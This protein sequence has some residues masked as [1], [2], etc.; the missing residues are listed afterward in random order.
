MNDDHL[1]VPRHELKALGEL[2]KE[3]PGLVSDL[4]VSVRRQDRIGIPGGARKPKRPSEQPLPYRIDASEAGD[5]LHNELGTWVRIVCEYRGIEDR[6]KDTTPALARW[7]DTNL[8]ALGMTEGAQA[9]FEAIGNSVDRVRWIVCPPPEVR[10]IDEHRLA[11]ARRLRLNARGI[12]TLATELG[13]EYRHLSK[14]RVLYLHERRY[15]APVPGPWRKDIILFLVGD[16]MD[17]HL[18]HPIREERAVSA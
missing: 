7:L 2:L 9:A 12:A 17:A 6:P 16:V 15:I 4:S 5:E 10:H 18:D 8:I 14:R 11:E 3:I 13:D 1:F